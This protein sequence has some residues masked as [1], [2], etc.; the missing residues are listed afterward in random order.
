MSW[1]NVVDG[2]PSL[3]Q[4]QG[5]A[6]HRR[7]P[8]MQLIAVPFK[9]TYAEYIYPQGPTCVRSDQMKYLIAHFPRTSPLHARLRNAQV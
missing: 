4:S 9:P 1:T 5:I 8:R 6:A 7:K 3:Q 2:L